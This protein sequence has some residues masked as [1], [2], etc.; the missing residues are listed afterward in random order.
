MV[1][2]FG[3]YLKGRDQASSLEVLGLVVSQPLDLL[4]EL[5]SPP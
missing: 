1:E 2:N 3:K 4:H 5:V